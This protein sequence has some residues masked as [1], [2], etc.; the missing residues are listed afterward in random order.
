MNLFADSCTCAVRTAK[1]RF[2]PVN[3]CALTLLLSWGA[4]G[5][6]VAQDTAGANVLRGKEVTEENLLKALTPTDKI[7]SRSLRVR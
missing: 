7:I 3:A 4:I 5:H 2:A 6:A 1:K